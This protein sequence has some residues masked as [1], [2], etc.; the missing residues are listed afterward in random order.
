M[1]V[2][3][4]LMHAGAISFVC[5][6]ALEQRLLHANTMIE[7]VVSCKIMQGPSISSLRINS[8]LENICK[9]LY[10]DRFQVCCKPNSIELGTRIDKNT[11]DFELPNHSP[12][13]D[14][15]TIK[16]KSQLNINIACMHCFVSSSC[17]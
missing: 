2:T 7:E 8:Y 17:F 16:F 6:G 10:I 4:A 3:K 1:L 14:M 12:Y 9:S 5:S 11:I 13:V 15:P